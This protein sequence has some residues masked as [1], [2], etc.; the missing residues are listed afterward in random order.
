MK[1]KVLKMT[2]LNRNILALLFVTLITACDNSEKDQDSTEITENPTDTYI[3]DVQG[4]FVPDRRVARFDV[5][6]E[7]Y[8]GKFVLRG[9]TTNPE[10]LAS[11]KQKLDSARIEYVDSIQVLSF[12]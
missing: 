11:L 3:R 9:E 12:K 6:S 2:F 1:N 4:E 7:A 10:A 8:E 5:E